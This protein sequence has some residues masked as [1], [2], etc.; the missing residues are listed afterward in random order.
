MRVTAIACLDWGHCIKLRRFL[1]ICKEMHFEHNSAYYY[2][3]QTKLWQNEAWQF[4]ENNVACKHGHQGL[5][6]PSCTFQLTWHAPGFNYTATEHTS[7]HQAVCLVIAFLVF[8]SGSCSLFIA[9]PLLEFWHSFC[10][11]HI[12]LVCNSVSGLV[13]NTY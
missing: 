8:V 7:L 4:P 2:R 1:S 5:Q 12:G 3:Q 6:F 10:I 11:M 9:W 13:T